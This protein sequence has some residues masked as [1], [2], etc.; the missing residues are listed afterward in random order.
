VVD[1]A[2]HLRTQYRTKKRFPQPTDDCETSDN[3]PA[4][5]GMELQA[6]LQWTGNA[7]VN[8]LRVHAFDTP[9][10]TTGCAEDE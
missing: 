7:T 5:Y 8:A 3:K 6:R 4:R 2:A 9:E 1:C 10:E